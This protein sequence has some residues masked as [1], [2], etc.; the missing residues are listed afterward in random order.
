M[1]L[2][3]MGYA[4]PIAIVFSRPGNSNQSQCSAWR[5]AKTKVVCMGVVNF[6]GLIPHGR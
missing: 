4:V 6:F 3:L 2:L 1:T 5:Q